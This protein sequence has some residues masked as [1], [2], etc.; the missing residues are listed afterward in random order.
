[1]HLG[2]TAFMKLLA[3]FK[4]SLREA[5]DSKVFYVMVGLSSLVI[6]FALTLSFKPQPALE[7][8]KFMALSLNSDLS[9]LNPGKSGQFGSRTTADGSRAYVVTNVKPR[10]GLTESPGSDYVVTIVAR[11]FKDEE[12]QKARKDSGEIEE[13]I[14]ERFGTFDEIKAV[15]VKSVRLT[16]PE[17]S[18]S[19]AA[20]SKQLSFEVVTGPTKVTRLRWF[21]EP[22]LFFGAIPMPFLKEYPFGMLGM[23]LYMVEG[24]I[25]SGWGA[26]VAILLSIII[27]S[28]FIPNMLRKGTVDLL[29]VKPIRRPLLLI[30]KFL[31]GLLFIFLNTAFVVIGMWLAVGFRSGIWTW[32]FLLT[33]LILTYFFAILYSV[34]TLFGVL[35]RSPIVAILMTCFIWGF[36]FAVGVLYQLFGGSQNQESDGSPALKALSSTVRA[37]HFVLPRTRDLDVLTNRLLMEDLSTGDLTRAETVAPTHF[38]WGESLTVSAIFIALMLAL[39]CWRFAGTDY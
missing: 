23:Q 25:I 30:L 17:S 29:L 2:E 24:T 11:F 12:F 3:V 5:I 18:E 19:P 33:I 35:T 31:G 21:H 36:L 14:K 34:S 7:V 15:E 26:W 37:I 10:E 6:L 16:D 13:H 20:N 8:M 1:M 28:F 22:S 27:T 38:S 39:S 9:A 32:G 4:D